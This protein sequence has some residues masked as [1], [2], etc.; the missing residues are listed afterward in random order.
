MH[1]AP[2][3]QSINQAALRQLP[4]ILSR[5]LPGGKR[6]GTEY[7]ALNPRR[8]D[9][10]L[11][12][13]KINITTG[14]WKDFASADQGGDPISLVAYLE[15]IKQAHA[16]EAIANYLGIDSTTGGTGGTGGTS[17]EGPTRARDSGEPNPSHTRPRAGGTSGT[18]KWDV[19]APVPEDAPSLPRHGKYG[20][21]SCIWTYRDESGGTLCHVCRFDLPGE[22][23]QFFPLTYCEG[24]NGQR[25]WRWQAL[26]EP[27]PLYNLDKL[28]Q[29]PDAFVIVCEGEK[30][31][32]AAALLFPECVTT[33]MV[34]GAQSPR[35]ADWAPLSGRNVYLWPDND[36]PGQRCMAEVCKLVRA[37]GARSV[38]ELSLDALR[39]DPATLQRIDALPGGWDAADAVAGGWTA[40]RVHSLKRELERTEYPLW[41]LPSAECEA[42][43]ADFEPQETVRAEAA[44][45]RK[46]Q[47][48]PHYK[49]DDRGVWYQG[50]DD[51]GTPL[52]PQWICSRLD[53]IATTRD[54]DNHNWGRLLEFKDR[55]GHKHVWAMPMELLKGDGADYRGE[56]LRMGLEIAPGPKARDHLMR[57]ITTAH[58]TDKARCTDRT[59]WHG[60]VYVRPDRT[61]GRSTERVLFQSPTGAG[62]SLV[63]NGSPQD[64]RDNVSH[65][66]VGNSRLIF[67]VSAAFA[68]PLLHL[69][70]EESGGFHLRGES[71][72]GKT[73]ALHVAASVYGGGSYLQ[74]WRATINGLEA[75]AA[76]HC[77]S[78]LILDELGQVDPKEAGESAYMLANG[79]GK[80]RANRIGAARPK[81]AWRLL[82]L[83]AGEIGLAEHMRQVGKKA[84]V[85]QELRL[86][87]I[88]ADAGA[89]LGLFET[90]HDFES[91]AAFSRAL[92]DASRR[93]YGTAAIAFIDALTLCFETL[94]ARIVQARRDFLSNHLPSEASGQAHRIAGR[95]AL[96]GAAGEIATE[97]GMTGWPQGEAIRAAAA[98]FKAWLDAR[99]GGGNQERAAMLSQVRQFFELHGESR[100]SPWDAVEEGWRT[101]NRAGFRRKIHDEKDYYADETEYYVFPEVFK[102][103]I[104]AGFDSRAV[105]KLLVELGWIEPGGDG[106][107]SQK[108]RLPGIGTSVRCYHFTA[109]MMNDES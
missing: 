2:D 19:I 66:C 28:A 55:D 67:A 71:S 78:L 95:F 107:T 80:A 65:Y 12:S 82:F 45:A 52:E 70:G 77:D 47:A 11:G 46:E 87:D 73:T 58:P 92:S 54:A 14:K 57:Y 37:A 94:P 25:D 3:F 39:V 44:K 76:Q 29:R 81:S 99:G 60:R 85:G 16:A 96:V 74:R 9:R 93:Y 41:R 42:D 109:K 89:G 68:A 4:N 59:G 30:A 108:K 18:I 88:L 7:V 84:R 97:L 49:L 48:R 26:P 15:D 69:A 105:A 36:D 90:I 43:A 8:A 33:T 27:R 79:T 34:N 50:F 38:H 10:T 31:A 103:E 91:A 86:A 61:I 53:V 5:W 13:F 63:Q 24:P 106:K 17:S 98:C 35:K 51:D 101:V 6:E 83:S 56:L 100:F 20:A 62:F 104:C 22:K 1:N 102:N 75:L 21:P 64:W 23:K 32:E 72:T 40:E